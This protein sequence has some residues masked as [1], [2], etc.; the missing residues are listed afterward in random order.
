MPDK[1]PPS[2][3]GSPSDSRGKRDSRKPYAKPRLKRYGTL[4]AVTLG[5]VP[6]AGESAKVGTFNPRML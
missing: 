4:R 3:P 2:L 5:S 1:S 6:G